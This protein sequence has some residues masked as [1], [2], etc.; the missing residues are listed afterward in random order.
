MQR[1]L[2]GQRL[3]LGSSLLLMVV[4]VISGQV[5]AAQTHSFVMPD[6]QKIPLTRSTTEWGIEFRDRSEVEACAQRLAAAGRGVVEDIGRMSESRVKLL[7]VARTSIHRRNLVREDAA[8]ISVR[9]VFRFPGCKSPA[10]CTGEIIVKVRDDLTPAQRTDLWAHYRLQLIEPVAGLHDVYRVQPIAVDADEVLRAE[11]LA[12]DSRTRWA[13]P[14]FR[15]VPRL[16]QVTPSDQFFGRQWHLQNTGQSGG[17]QGADIAATDAWVLSQ[18]QDI[19]L[20]MFDDAC[21]VDHEDLAPNYIGQGHDPSLPSNDPD[22]D[23]PRPKQIGDLHGTAV[24][25][26]AAARAN[27]LGV[28]GVS[29]LSRFTVSRGLNAFL[30]SADIASVYTFARQ[31]E[32]DVH[33]NSWGFEPGTP[34][35]TVV[36]EAIETAFNDGRDLDGED[37]EDPPLGMVVVFASGN[38][39]DGTGATDGIELQRGL[40][41][42]TLATVIGVGASTVRD[43]L[44]TYSNFGV[45]VDVLA[46]GGDEEALIATTDVDDASS[47]F[48]DGFNIGG[49]DQFGITDLDS[50]GKYTQTFVG[51]SAACPIVAGVASLILAENPLLT[52]TDVRLILE[53]T[54]D[55]I[56][57]ADADYHLITSRSLR[58]GYGRVNANSAVLA[59]EQSLNNGGRTWPERVG[60][61][62]VN[63][64]TLRWQAN[65]ATDEFLVL[66]SDSG[67]DFIP[68]DGRCYSSD[69]AGC[70][71]LTVT[72][73]PDGVNVLSIQ[74]CDG[75]CEPGTAFSDEFLVP[76]GGKFFAI[77]ARSNIGRYA[78]GVAVDSAGN[79]TDEASM[80]V[81][82]D[83][84]AIGSGGTDPGGT[85]IEPPRIT[86]NATP[87]SGISPLVVRYS[88]NATS[89]LEIDQDRTEWDYDIADNVLVDARTRNA[90]STPYEVPA[91]QVQTFTARLTMCD[92]EGNCGAASVMI[93][94]TGAGDSDTGGT[95]SQG[96]IRLIVGVPGSPDSNV[97]GGKSPFAVELS[98]D[99]TKLSGTVQSILWDLGDGETAT[100]LFVP[101]TYINTSE[102]DLVIP[103]TA[104]VT[105][106]TAGGATLSTVATRLITVTPGDPEAGPLEPPKL[107]GVGVP[108]GGGVASSPCAAMGFVPLLFSV[109]GLAWFRRRI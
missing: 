84:D 25:G 10:V 6:G 67:F 35:P 21:D 86:I 3:S 107:P 104:T 4:V 98:L 95:I 106:T 76:A 73:L 51:T 63:G 83:I 53:H 38:G 7:R 82:A 23:N 50:E 27:A 2:V 18:G 100:S 41:L 5:C 37:G 56:N 85:T 13:Q 60:V 32:V 1:V 14:N 94:V 46:P 65:F 43:R 42:S 102:V 108:E 87:L 49:F 70:G 12:D 54:T 93:T 80:I 20:G 109:L 24:M 40:D 59:A 77:F 90:V 44:A 88:G 72:A 89:V 36:S 74:R 97:D 62:S 66:E 101:H 75:P 92:V 103:I 8:I 57:P 15:L 30:S 29:Y 69:Q 55:Q 33:I 68:D 64:G 52:A 58:Y 71:S 105:S 34:V 11:T 96:Q 39:Q 26:L 48:E 99:A 78:F 9:P 19:L 47:V 17:V 16:H 28:R 79:I 22:F 91:G 31:Q 81:G 61:V 45:D